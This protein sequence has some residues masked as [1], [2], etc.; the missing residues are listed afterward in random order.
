MLYSI[1]HACFFRFKPISPVNLSTKNN[2][3][4]SDP[5]GSLDKLHARI[6]DP[7]GSLDKT[8]GQIYDLL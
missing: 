5:S 4:I 1:D 6:Y 2:L 3:R 8:L 7:G